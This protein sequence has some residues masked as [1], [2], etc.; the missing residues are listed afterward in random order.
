MLLAENYLALKLAEAWKEI[1]VEFQ[2]ACF[3]PNPSDDM[4]IS[5]FMDKMKI[6][7]TSLKKVQQSIL[8]AEKQQV[9]YFYSLSLTAFNIIYTQGRQGCQLSQNSPG[10]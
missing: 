10:K 1:D 2:R 4:I 3:T 8:K 7:V 5:N 9:L 6:W